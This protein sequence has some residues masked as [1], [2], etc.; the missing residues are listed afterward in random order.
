MTKLTLHLLM[1]HS[2]SSLRD[3][4]VHVE[5]DKLERLVTLGVE[6]ID[7]S[8]L[9]DLATQILPQQHGVVAF[10]DDSAGFIHPAPPFGLRI[11]FD[12]RYLRASV[13]KLINGTLALRLETAAAERM[14]MALESAPRV[15]EELHDAGFKAVIGGSVGRGEKGHTETDL[16]VF[17]YGTF[18]SGPEDAPSPGRLMTLAEKASSVPV[19]MVFEH[20]IANVDPADFTSN[21]HLAWDPVAKR[22]VPVAGTLEADS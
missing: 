13:S 8:L 16:D 7:S 9:L 3:L 1:K 5:I 22:C 15:L 20:W 6:A 19:D 14:R 12:G 17:V 21:R 2:M 10:T 18:D 4:P 11:H